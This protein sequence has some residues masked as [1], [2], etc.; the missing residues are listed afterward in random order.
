MRYLLGILGRTAEGFEG[1]DQ[2]GA[3]ILIRVNNST[4]MFQGNGFFGNYL[5]QLGKTHDI[6]VVGMIHADIRFAQKHH[7][8][9]FAH[10]AWLHDRLV[11]VVGKSLGGDIIWSASPPGDAYSVAP[12]FVSTLDSCSI[13]IPKS[14]FGFSFDTETF[15]GFH[16]CVEDFCLQ[17]E[18]SRGISP[19]IPFHGHVTHLGEMCATVGIPWMREHMQYREKFQKKWEHRSF[20]L[21]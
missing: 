1:L 12:R 6:D 4:K 5:L 19:H 9:L 8:M 15:D 3:D 11:G 14:L 18:E 16:L 21:T 20:A 17:V 7:D 2:M 10:H 13:F